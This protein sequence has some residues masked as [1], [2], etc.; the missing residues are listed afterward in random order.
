MAFL[1]RAITLDLDDTLW[2]IA[3]AI[4]RAEA[5][6]DAWLLAHAPR[7]AARWPLSARRTLRDAV[8]RAAASVA[9]YSSGFGHAA[10]E[11]GCDPV[12]RAG[13]RDGITGVGV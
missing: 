4:D 5:A 7:A 12:R 9:A 3:P 8:D 2:P 6:L 11:P 10:I 1:I 13:A